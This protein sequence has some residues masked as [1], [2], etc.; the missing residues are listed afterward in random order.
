MGWDTSSKAAALVALEWPTSSKKGWQEVR[1]VSELNLDVDTT[2]SERLLWG[3]D[4]L[5][6]SS[7]WKLRDVDL[8]AVGVGPGS[9]TGLR[10]GVTT[11]RTL[12]HSVQK[13]LIPVSSLAAL[14][15][16]AALWAAQLEKRVVVVA[17][18]DACK[19]ELFALFGSAR[20]IADCVVPAMGDSSGLWKRGVD[21]FVITPG[22]LLKAVKKKM[23]EG[24]S[25][26]A[27]EALWLA[28]GEGRMR[29]LDLWKKLPAS[30]ELQSVLP[31]S[32]GVQ[33]R[34]LGQL[35]WE[36]YQAGMARPALKVV[37]RYLRVSDAELKLKAGLLPPGP[38]RG[39]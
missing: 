26:V 24:T 29:Y 18:T 32:Q 10:I 1:L 23:S 5:L 33:G 22:E 39:H 21:E 36:A 37:P 14:A 12:A 11:A 19:G 6:E 30:K 38:T 17:A 34:Y 31:F 27:K 9:F 15:R 4:Q 25:S 20:S 28:V 16:P 7:R 3:L 13:P 35:A 8:F 2:Q